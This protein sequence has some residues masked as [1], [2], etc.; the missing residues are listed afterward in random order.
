MTTTAVI[1]ARVGSTR[2]PRKVLADLGG[3]PM[4]SRVHAATVAAKSVDRVVVATSTAAADQEIEDWADQNGTACVRGSERDVLQ[5]FTEVLDAFP[6]TT[7]IVRLT[8][9]CP[10]L[11]PTVIDAVVKLLHSAQADFAA[12][13]LPPP[14]RRT[15]PVGL[16]VEVCTAA[17]LLTAAEQATLPY[18]REHVM[19]YLYEPPGR[20]R[21]SL[22]DLDEDLSGYR[23]TV[24]TPDDLAAARAIVEIVGT[25]PVGWIEVLDTVRSNPWIT[26]INHASRQR[27][28]SHTQ[29]DDAPK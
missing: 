8:A 28:V 14:F 6:D 24:D 3:A 2:L 23:W 10:F 12:N 18:Q 13:R 16:D 27:D 7:T 21:V 19:P 11:D 22:L 15:Y 25:D 29:T 1:Q 17:A 26:D 9:D 20:F 4:L 5:R